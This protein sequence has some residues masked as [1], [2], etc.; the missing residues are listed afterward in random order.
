[1][2]AESSSREPIATALAVAG[3][4]AIVAACA[5][6]ASLAD[7][8]AVRNVADVLTLDGRIPMLLGLG[9]GDARVAAALPEAAGSALAAGAVLLA[10]R[11]P[12]AHSLAAEPGPGDADG[13]RPAGIGRVEAATAVCVL[14]VFA[15][16]A[17]RNLDLPVRGDEARTFLWFTAGSIWTTLSD[18]S[19]PNNHVLHS[20]AVQAARRLL[21]DDPAALR[22]P[23]FLAACLT[24]PAMW[25]FVRREFGRLAAAFAT[26]LVGTSPLFIEYATNARGYT[27]T[28]LAFMVLLLCGQGIVR[29]PEDHVRWGAVRG[30]G[31]ARRVHPSDHGLSGRD[32]DGVDGAGAV[33]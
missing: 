8:E 27:L 25:W 28:G 12:I 32:R 10:F 20:L 13:A 5:L 31:R 33:A 7:V 9:R 30:R 22:T 15:A 21:G 2:R 3:W 11:R 26:T 24:L 16:L 23:A 6:A 18:Y 19:A 29:R 14:T 4:A 1:M 17:A